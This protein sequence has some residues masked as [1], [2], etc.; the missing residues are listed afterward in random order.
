MTEWIKRT[1]RREKVVKTNPHAVD[2][3]K[4]PCCPII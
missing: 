2:L 1:R 4:S 3:C